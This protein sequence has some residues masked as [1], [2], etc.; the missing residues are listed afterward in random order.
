MPVRSCAVYT[1]KSS[2]EGLEQ[3]F[4]SLDAQR[5][6]GEAFIKSQAH[7]GWRLVKTR[8]DD[9]G[10]SGGNLERPALQ[11]LLA[12]IRAGKV[13]T[14]VVYKVDRLTRSLSDF[15]KLIELFEAR[16]VS[17]VSVT[18]QFNTTTSM[19]RLM[20]NVLLSFAQ[21]ER[22]VTGER[23]RDKIAASK[24]KGLWMGGMPAIGY[25]IRE[26][27]LVINESEAKVIRHIFSRYA[28]LRSVGKL[29]RE[30]KS[31]GYLTRHF[32]SS[33]GRAYG[34]R[35]FSRGHLYRI[36]QNRIYLGHV[37]HKEANYPGEHEAIIG[38]ELWEQV[39]QVLAENRQALK[40]GAHFAS[41]SLLK[42]LIFDDA[43]NRMSPIHANKG[44]RRYRYYVSQPLL[45][46]RPEEAGSAPRVPAHDLEKLVTDK[47]FEM[48]AADVR[49]RVATS[50]HKEGDE[51]QLLVRRVLK[52][53]EVSERLVRIQTDVAAC[54]SEESGRGEAGA[55]EPRTVEVP[56]DFVRW[57]GGT[58]IVPA[59]GSQ[60]LN[61]RS[62]SELIRAVAR[63]QLWW[64]QLLTGHARTVAEVARRAGV[65]T[66]YARRIIRASFLAPDIVEAIL[67]GRQP[68][69]LS[70]LQLRMPPADWAE[71]RRLLGFAQT[72]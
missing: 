46:H 5:E 19:G 54:L 36:L 41:G 67:D 6:A 1:R 26:R 51:R 58:Q 43:S 3:E 56:F 50:N 9:G 32:T 20:L 24:K 62:N 14:V 55:S 2:E 12:D 4:N 61:D 22:E 57:R 39:Q 69:A 38:Q 30:L 72:A 33:S 53:V 47:I 59:D 34:G 10:Y 13:N 60:A 35:P 31:Q 65:T 68:A 7:E 11:G 25:D 17:F 27:K 29:G 23:I 52:R 37:V 71:Q 49:T 8:Y 16:G 44:G 21:F 45:Q 70:V 15:A 28:A 64:N 40:T 42:G 18:Q 66:R 63:G 48:L